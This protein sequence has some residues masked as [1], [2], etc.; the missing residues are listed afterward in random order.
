MWQEFLS[1]DAV[2]KLE[3]VEIMRVPPVQRR[4][5]PIVET[6]ALFEGGAALA[7][8]SRLIDSNRL[9]GRPDGGEG[10][11]ADT[12][13]VDIGRLDY[14]DRRAAGNARTQ[15]SRQVTGRK[16]TGRTAARDDYSQVCVHAPLPL[17]LVDSASSE[18][19]EEHTSELQ[20]LR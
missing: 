2:G 10:T 11:F 9:E 13:D 8:E 12:D 1:V 3:R 18:R 15:R 17:R 5:G 4:T 19:S 20:S 7:Q 16:P 6:D 14:G